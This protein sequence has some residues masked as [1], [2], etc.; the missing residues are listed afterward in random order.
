MQILPKVNNFSINNKLFEVEVVYES[1]AEDSD[2]DEDSDE[3]DEEDQEAL[4]EF[5]E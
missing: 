5:A 1:E 3:E 4:Q 2:S